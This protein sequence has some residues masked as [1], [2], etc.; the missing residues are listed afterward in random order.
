MKT[1]YIVRHAKS[2]WD[3]HSLDDF[4][5]PLNQR[6]ERDAPVMGEV[7]KDHGARPDIIIS[8][9]AK[10]AESTAMA[11][12]AASRYSATNIL[13]E[14]KI[15]EASVATLISVIQNIPHDARTALMVG[16]N[17]GF[18]DLV[19]YLTGRGVDN[20]PTCGACEIEFDLT[21]WSK[22]SKRKGEL[23]WFDFP[24]NHK[25]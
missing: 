5:R 24:K 18:T 21:S 9:P 25:R 22:V 1:L 23:I 20:V 15:Y 7:L 13:F 6:G 17:P 16:H 10:R 14:P 4:D 8:S 2:S 12:A 11:I 3:D 19:Y